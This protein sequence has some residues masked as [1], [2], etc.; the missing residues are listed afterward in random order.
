MRKSA[1]GASHAEISAEE[2]AAGAES[3]NGIKLITAELGGLPV[4]AMRE[5]M[6]DLR[7]KLPKA[8]VICLAGTDKGKLSLLLHVSRDLHDRFTAPA[9]IQ[10]VAAVCGGKGGGGRPDL[11]QAGAPEPGKLPDAFAKLKEIIQDKK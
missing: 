8:V 6:D 10:S 5:I 2:L 7:G 1:G 9:L 4:K 3:I 11:A